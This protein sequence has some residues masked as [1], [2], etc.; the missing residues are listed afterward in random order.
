MAVQPR[1]IAGSTSVPLN[2][3][4]IDEGANV[5]KIGR[6]AETDFIASIKALGIQ[7]PLI[8]RKNGKG[9]VVA[10]GGKRLEAARALAQSGDLAADAPIPVIV[11]D[12]SDA[13]ARELSLALNLVRID[14]H[15]VDAYRAFAS[16]HTDKQQPLDVD[17][18][19]IRFGVD[20]KTVRQR[21]ALGALDDVILDAWQRQDIREA[22]VQAFTLLPDKKA[23]AVLYAKLKKNDNL[24]S[25]SIRQA[26]KAG[27]Q[28]VGAMIATVGAAAYEA[29]GGKITHDLF[30]GDHVVSDAGL[31][32]T[33]LDEKLAATV[34]SLKAD[35]W[36]WVATARPDD[37]YE[38]GRIQPTFKPTPDEKAA[39]AKLKKQ[40]A[41]EDQDYEEQEKAQAE[42]DALNDAIL[43][44]AITDKHRASSGCIVTVQD[45]EISI[46]LG[47]IK[48]TAR[49]SSKDGGEDADTDVPK[50]KPVKKEA[51]GLTKALTDRLRE[52]RETAIKAALVSHPHSH[53]LATLLA[54]IVASQIRPGGYGMADEVAA[55]L[56]AIA[57]GIDAK[58]I[59][60]A[61]AKA[62][63]A[64]GYFDGAGK[65]FCLAAITEAIN[66]DEARKIS[67][68][69][70]ADIAKF[71][72]TNVG[73]TG[74]LPKELR[75][76]H[77]TGPQK[78]SAPTKAKKA[79][80]PPRKRRG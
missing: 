58:V 3:L 50:E 27:Q 77:Y 61:M 47:W 66:A 15:P 38:Y 55:K 72:L 2:A 60:A 39:L 26:I 52:Q 22:D 24:Y 54:G 30:G 57:A 64:K 31:L 43:T 62:F 1:A 21:L 73:K 16:L 78:K 36:S 32:Q 13:E 25:G 48:P 80:A 4:Q 9:Y 37:H 34:E 29:R 28:N 56:D 11:A 68:E 79:S 76:P 35:G 40:I 71:A 12:V 6:G 41:N 14:M 49:A 75:T 51:A 63:D 5:R 59:N 42:Y 74:W 53:P 69:K 19:S 44:R 70:K 45:G 20:T 65:S 7:V 23:Q 46:N 18:L 17:A 8:V 33:M 67:D 10:D